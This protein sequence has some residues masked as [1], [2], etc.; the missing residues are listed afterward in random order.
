MELQGTC[1][2]CGKVHTVTAH[3]RM[4]RHKP[5]VQW[6][7]APEYCVGSGAPPYES[8]C[9]L[10]AQQRDATMQQAAA[11]A[12]EHLNTAVTGNMD[13]HGR[14]WAKVH[15]PP[16][17]FNPEGG[18]QWIL[19]RIMSTAAGQVQVLDGMG[20]LLPLPNY[21]HVAG[22]RASMLEHRLATLDA[23]HSAALERVAWLDLRV[24]AWRPIKLR[25]TKPHPTKRLAEH[26]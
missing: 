25:P 5:D 20:R 3:G 2:V 10:A 18:A 14:S 13:I 23:W 9:A 21:T 11:L 1:Q 26:H 12:L 17:A 15:L 7:D 24:K 22:A 16:N 19:G 8:D 4:V 6:M